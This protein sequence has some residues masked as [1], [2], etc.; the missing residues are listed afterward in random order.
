VQNMLRSDS[1]DNKYQIVDL[2]SKTGTFLYIPLTKPLVLKDEH[3]IQ[4]SN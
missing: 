1:G 2:Q 4:L 3:I